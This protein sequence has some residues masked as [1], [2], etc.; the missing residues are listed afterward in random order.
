MFG[1]Y[2]Q[3]KLADLIFQQELQRRLTAA[4]SPILSTGAHP[5]YAITNLQTSGPAGQT[6]LIFRIVSTL[7][8][9]W[10]RRMPPT[11]PLPTLFAAT[12]PAARGP[13]VITAP[14]NFKEL[15]GFPVPAKIVPAAKESEFSETPMERTRSDWSGSPYT[16]GGV[17]VLELLTGHGVPAVEP[18]VGSRPCP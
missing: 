2:S 15:I 6:P 1:A 5:G 13:G 3:S 17:V 16:S 4:R 10:P 7:L 9:P 12:S 14:I 11:A 8:K 18:G